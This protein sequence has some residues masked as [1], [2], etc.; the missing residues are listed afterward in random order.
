MLAIIYLP[1]NTVLSFHFFTLEIKMSNWISLHMQP[2]DAWE[3]KGGGG[4]FR[5]MLADLVHGSVWWRPLC[6]YGLLISAGFGEPTK[7]WRVGC[8]FSLCCFYVLKY[9]SENSWVGC[10]ECFQRL[11][12]ERGFFPALGG[13]HPF[14]CAV[15]A[16]LIVPTHKGPLC[17]PVS[18]CASVMR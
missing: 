10:N 15:R 14:S 5:W 9:C 18:K 4:G 6:L 13:H 12:F 16:S 11:S 7:Y 17:E 2:G 8:L 3:K 1:A